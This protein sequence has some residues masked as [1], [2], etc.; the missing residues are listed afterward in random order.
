LRVQKM[1]LEYVLLQ[2]DNL[3][4][5][6]K[7]DNGTVDSIVC[8][9]PYG[10]KFMAKDWDSIGEG[11]DQREW[12]RAWLTEAYRVLKPNGVI[13]SFSGTK[14]F[15]HLF[16]TMEEV[17]F[18]EVKA[19][20]WVYGS[21]FPKSLNLS[22]TIDKKLGVK[23]K[24]L[25]IVKGMGK[26]N[27]EWNGTAQG[28]SENSLKSEYMQTAATSNQAQMFEGYGTALKPAWECVVVGIKK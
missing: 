12:H 14:T 24:E 13:K 8:D 18:T 25:G 6:A 27:P 1:S 26:Q 5:F 11:A 7:I 21:G 22:K 23:Q 16:Y 19:E 4:S 15:H 3:E 10:L 9:P 17:G 28:R 2:G 20:A